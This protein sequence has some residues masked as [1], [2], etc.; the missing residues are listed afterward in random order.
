MSENES[1]RETP[2]DNLDE[3][4]T[5]C[6]KQY[7]LRD[8]SPHFFFK[9]KANRFGPPKSRRRIIIAPP[10]GEGYPPR[11]Q[12]KPP[13]P[14]G[15]KLTVCGLRKQPEEEAKGPSAED[16]V[17]QELEDWTGERRKLRVLLDSC[18]NIDKW[19][20]GKQAISAQE[21]SVLRKKKERREAQKIEIEAKLT[22]TSS[23]EV[24][25]ARSVPQPWILCNGLT[26]CLQQVLFFL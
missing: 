19:L 6:F 25:W 2:Q 21:E 8:T 9:V 24:N 12:P 14:S 4:L 26:A 22:A 10:M 5:H 11:F 13:E 23:I 18:V 3:Y 7:K 20:K 16:D 1:P 17:V 15:E